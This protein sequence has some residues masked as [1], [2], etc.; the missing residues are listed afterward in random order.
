MLRVRLK[1]IAASLLIPVL[2]L[3]GACEPHPEEIAEV[4]QT[5]VRDVANAGNTGPREALPLIEFVEDEFG[6]AS[7][8]ITWA[9]AAL[10]ADDLDSAKMI[11]IQAVVVAGEAGF[12]KVTL[13]FKYDP[14]TKHVAYRDALVGKKPLVDKDDRKVLLASAYEALKARVDAAQAKADAKAKAKAKKKKAKDAKAK[15]AHVSKNEAEID[16]S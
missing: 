15:V 10:P 7:P 11:G 12:P 5:I 8:S 3:L 1:E 6:A 9:S 2:M 14:A 16:R 4:Q 13:R